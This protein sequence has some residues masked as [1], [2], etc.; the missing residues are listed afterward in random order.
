MGWVMWCGGMGWAMWC[1][2]MG[3]V[4]LC[5]GMGWIVLC[6]GMGW[7][8]WC[9]GM[10]WD[11]NCKRDEIRSMVVWYGVVCDQLNGDVWHIDRS[12][13]WLMWHAIGNV[14]STSHYKPLMTNCYLLLTKY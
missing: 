9:G 6:D 12:C 5:G 2:V 7:V 4:V 8:V 1:D 14:L 3:W 11:G 13:V 10:G